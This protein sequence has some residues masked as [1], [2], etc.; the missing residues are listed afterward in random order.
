[1]HK[2]ALKILEL[3]EARSW[4]CP[5]QLGEQMEEAEIATKELA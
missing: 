2:K 5:M 3:L 4:R 1:V